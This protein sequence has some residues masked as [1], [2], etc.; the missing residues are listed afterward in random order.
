MFGIDHP[1]AA[2]YVVSRPSLARFGGTIRHNNLVNL[3]FFW[4]K[5]YWELCLSLRV[6]KDLPATSDIS[7]GAMT[8]SHLAFNDITIP[9]LPRH[10][11][12]ARIGKIQLF[13]SIKEQV[14]MIF[15]YRDEIAKLFGVLFERIGIAPELKKRFLAVAREGCFRFSN[16]S[17]F[18]YHSAPPKTSRLAF[19]ILRGASS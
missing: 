18:L 15:K 16:T 5:F 11:K 7:F 4:I 17:R 10:A 19:F 14:Q 2:S 9:P 12:I 3:Y 1:K 6:Q 8:R 13:V